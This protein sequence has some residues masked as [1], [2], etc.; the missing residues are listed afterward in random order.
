[1]K[2]TQEKELDLI[3]WLVVANLVAWLIVIVF[4]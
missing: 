4:V 2:T 3:A 1:M